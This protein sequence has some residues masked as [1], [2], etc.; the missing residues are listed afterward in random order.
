[1]LYL[2][3]VVESTEPKQVYSGKLG[4]VSER[5]IKDIIIIEFCARQRF[6]RRDQTFGLREQTFGGRDID[7]LKVEDPCYEI[8]QCVC[9][10]LQY[11]L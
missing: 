9:L 1:V 5:T 2:L 4:F 3:S 6:C 11:L 7:I 10:L 8:R